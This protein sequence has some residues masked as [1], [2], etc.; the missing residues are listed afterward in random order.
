MELIS[1][2]NLTLMRA[3]DSFDVHKGNRFSTYATLSLMKGFARS[4]PQMQADNRTAGH[5]PAALADLPDG[6]P[7]RAMERLVHRDHLQQLLSSL[8]SREREVLLAHFGL[9]DDG[10]ATLEQVGSRLG[11]SKQRVRQIEQNALAKLRANDR[12][13]GRM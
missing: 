1:D 9:Q 8:D 7:P 2:G 12:G 13:S 10:P 6:R 5:N 3:V 11:L 4:V